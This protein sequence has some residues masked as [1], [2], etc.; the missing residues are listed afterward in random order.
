[1]G[2]MDTPPDLEQ[3]DTL[4]VAPSGA[5]RDTHEEMDPLA[6]SVDMAAP[7]RIG[8]PDRYARS[9]LLGQF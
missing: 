2:R 5:S 4:K 8:I 3:R 6:V 9:D 1:M 7:R